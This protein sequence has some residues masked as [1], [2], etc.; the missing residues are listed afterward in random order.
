MDDIEVTATELFDCAAGQLQV[1]SDPI[2][3]GEPLEVS[4]AAVNAGLRPLERVVV[5]FGWRAQ[6]GSEPVWDPPR[7]VVPGDSLPPGDSIAVP[8]T[9]RPPL[10]GVLALCAVVAAEGDRNSLND[11]SQTSLRVGAQAGRIVISEI[12]HAPAPGEPE[13]IELTNNGSVALH[14]QGWS[15]GD[16]ADPEGRELA[17]PAALVAPRGFAVVAQDTVR[18]RAFRPDLPAEVAL[19]AGLP[20]LNNTN[21]CLI[22][23]DPAGVVVDS[24]PYSALWHHPSQVAPIGRSL[25]RVVLSSG[26]SDRWNWGSSVHPSGGTPGL[27]NS[28][29]IETAVP[30]ALLSASPNPFSPDNDG[31]DDRTVVRFENP[32]GAGTMSLRVFDVRGRLVRTVASNEP[33]AERGLAVWDGLDDERRRVR[34]GIYILLLQIVPSGDAPILTAK[35]CVVVAARL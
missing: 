20:S 22:L 4:L 28:I 13:W 1:P 7:D 12:M 8:A 33:C 25:E 35:G 24:V 14:L 23:H 16:E 19:L 5:R 17:P 3:E 21:D 2:V 15:V 18:F 10:P 27:P 30:H 26:S 29:A 34:I 32:S 6:A 11:S 31:V 9:V